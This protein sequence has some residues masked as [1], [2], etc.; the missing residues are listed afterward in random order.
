MKE[1]KLRIFI[2]DDDSFF[3]SALKGL[4]EE[5]LPNAMVF[6]F[7]KVQDCMSMLFYNP[8]LIFLDYN[9]NDDKSNHQLDGISGL[10]LMTS[11]NPD[12]RI[13]MISS[14]NFSDK[15]TYAKKIGA[16]DFMLKTKELP[17]SILQVLKKYFPDQQVRAQTMQKSSQN[18]TQL[19]F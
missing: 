9:F 6:T 11:A 19:R 1:K 13:I 18:N 15:L 7:Q 16:T 14:I 12:I 3:T 10:N 2:T 5:F 4:I 17:Q 8:D